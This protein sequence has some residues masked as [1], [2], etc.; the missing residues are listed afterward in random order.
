MLDQLC[1]SV[2]GA[3]CSWWIY[4]VDFYSQYPVKY[5]HYYELIGCSVM[6]KCL[7]T[8]MLRG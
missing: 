7:E 6:S 1:P 4:Q 5:F 8:G 3:L 2:A